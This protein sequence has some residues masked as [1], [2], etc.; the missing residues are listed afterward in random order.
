M[1]HKYVA[2]CFLLSGA[3][4]LN[5]ETTSAQHFNSLYNIVDSSNTLIGA[6]GG[7]NVIIRPD[8]SYFLTAYSIISASQKYELANLTVN[9][10]GTNVISKHFVR[11]NSTLVDG[12][13][14]SLRK[15]MGGYLSP[16]SIYGFNVAT[17]GYIQYDSIGNVI[18]TRVY[19]DTLKYSEGP[20]YLSILPDSSFLICGERDSV[21]Y[22][23][24]WGYVQHI[25][26]TGQLLWMRTYN[27]DTANENRFTSIE[28][29]PNHNILVGGTIIVR[30][31][32]MS[33]SVI[34]SLPWMLLLDSSGNILKDTMYST[35]YYHGAYV[36]GGNVF[37]DVNGGY[38]HWGGKDSTPAPFPQSINYAGNHP[39]YIAHLDSNFAID[40]RVSFPVF[41]Y[42]GYSGIR[43][44]WQ[45]IQTKD[46]GYLVMGDV[47]GA[48]VNGWLCKLNKNG[49]IK[50]EHFYYKDST[51]QAYLV[52]AEERPTSGFVAVGWSKGCK[53]CSQDVWLLSVDSN[54]C[55]LPGCS[56]GLAVPQEPV[57]AAFSLYP[58]PTTGAF[59][60]ESPAAGQLSLYNLQGQVV[61]R[62]TIAQGK[63]SL[64]LPIV[65]TAGLYVGQYRSNDGQYIQTVRVI[66][67]P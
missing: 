21:G 62:Y 24:A 38:F 34:F 53:T 8:N 58:N 10:F 51:Q 31:D 41:N 23:R 18:L 14:G 15:Y 33:N 40:W 37:S 25:S 29:L 28:E 60:V 36:H 55:E 52:D 5:V 47:A 2:W 44:I 19:T 45:V 1:L 59:T 30:F 66:Y 3:S 7:V 61:A 48:Y 26:A 35:H 46:S 49:Q 65:L 56:S 17:G 67:Q 39:D 50:W 27:R 16:L 22:K 11:G 12:V 42:V 32:T 20:F 54:G 6:G 63:T 43:I 57:A 64:S 4:C 9:Q 13:P